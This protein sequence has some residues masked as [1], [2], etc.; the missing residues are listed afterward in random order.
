MDAHLE[1]AQVPPLVSSVLALGADRCSFFC[2]VDAYRAPSDAAAAADAP[3][4]AELV[5]SAC[6]QSRSRPAWL[7]PEAIG[8][9]WLGSP[10]GPCA[11]ALRGEPYPQCDTGK[12]SD[13][14]GHYADLA[15][16]GCFAHDFD[17][18]AANRHFV[19]RSASTNLRQLL[20]TE[21]IFIGC[22]SNNK[23]KLNITRS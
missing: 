2:Y 21:S 22:F 4:S 14:D 23:L 12:L 9:F 3:R 8:S 15:A 18:V 11:K 10:C 19:H 13:F 1:C 17:D 20:S 16:D 7:G 6:K 5:I